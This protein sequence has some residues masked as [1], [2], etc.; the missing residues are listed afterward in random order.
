LQPCLIEILLAI[1]V[2]V[3]YH[4]TRF[5]KVAGVVLLLLATFQIAEHWICVEAGAAAVWWSRIGF[6]VSLVNRKQHFL[7]LG[8]VTA[9]G[10][11]IYFIFVP[12]AITGA[13]CGW[14]YV[15]F[16]LSNDRENRKP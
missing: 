16:N 5:G 3:R 14:N 1:Y 15:L 7:K 6:V 2:F 11:A 12:K 13:I 9:A 8:Y 10:F 4:T